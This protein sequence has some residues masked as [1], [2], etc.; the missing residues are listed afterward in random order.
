MKAEHEK[1][2]TAV[3]ESASQKES[4]ENISAYNLNDEYY[5]QLEFTGYSVYNIYYWSLSS[6]TNI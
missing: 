6:N 4:N 1:R 3:L 5:K 2:T